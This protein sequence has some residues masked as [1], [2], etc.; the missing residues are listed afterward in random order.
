MALFELHPPDTHHLQAALGWLELGNPSEA[1]EEL[2][3]L[4]PEALDH[5]DA[6][7]VRW[8]IC[9]LSSSWDAAVPIAELLVAT[10]P[11]RVGGWIHRAYAIR[12]AKNG[13]LQKAWDA[14]LPAA[15]LFPKEPLIPYNLACYTA[16]FGRLEEAWNWF[17]HAL[18]S[19]G[20]S[21]LIKMQA[22]ADD[23]LRPL[24][25]RIRKL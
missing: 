1:G 20:D 17:N 12:R 9:A 18:E 16:Q 24:W 14:L 5:P 10:D 21:F 11:A 13:G 2:A 7:E 6:L 22:L 15:R 19:A 4:S 3:R 25:D 23:D 8:Q